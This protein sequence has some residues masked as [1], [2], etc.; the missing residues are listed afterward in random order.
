LRSKISSL[1]YKRFKYL[2]ILI[3]ITM[4]SGYLPNSPI[5]AND[6]ELFNDRRNNTGGNKL[7]T[8]HIHL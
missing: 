6:K 5:M 2:N 4:F 1:V 8:K 7:R 3:I